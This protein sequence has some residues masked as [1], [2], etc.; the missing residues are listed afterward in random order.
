MFVCV[1]RTIILYIL[2]IVGMRMM[3]KRQIGQLQPS[4]FVTT[5]LLSELITSPILDVDIPLMG[6]VVPF[7]MVICFEIIV[8]W[9]AARFPI[10]KRVVDGRPC[11]LIFNGEIDQKKLFAM[12]MSVDELLGQLRLRGVGDVKDVQ[13]GVLEQNGQF[14][15][16]LRAGAAPATVD[17]LKLSPAHKGIAHPLVVQGQISDFHLQLLKKDR[18]W[19][20][21]ELS[22]RGCGLSDVLLFSLDDDMN[23]H[24]VKKEDN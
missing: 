2:L 17:D 14:S 23:F 11:L 13:Y 7:L 1:L 10:A 21:S 22:K 18:K 12:R 8:P 15:V 24:L 3:G 16:I 5:I 6:A 9:F 4:E 20:L 19:L